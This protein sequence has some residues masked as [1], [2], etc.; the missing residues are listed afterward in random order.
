MKELGVDL[1]DAFEE[2][3]EKARTTT[4]LDDLTSD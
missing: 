3:L 2:K 1:G 4:N